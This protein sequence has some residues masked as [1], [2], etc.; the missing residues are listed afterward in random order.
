MKLKNRLEIGKIWKEPFYYGTSTRGIQRYNTYQ[1]IKQLI[2]PPYVPTDEYIESVKDNCHKS[3]TVERYRREQRSVYLKKIKREIGILHK[4]NRWIKYISKGFTEYNTYHHS[5]LCWK[6]KISFQYCG[7]WNFR[8]PLLKCIYL[9]L[10]KNQVREF[11][12]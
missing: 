4:R 11:T 10:L 1:H 12:S 2:A 6:Q 5:Y 3:F 9:I 7:R 8:I